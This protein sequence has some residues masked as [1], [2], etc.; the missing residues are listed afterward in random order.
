[1]GFKGGKANDFLSFFGANFRG[2]VTIFIIIAVLII[3]NTIRINIY[4]HREEIGIMKL[5]GATDDYVKGP[6]LFQGLFFGLVSAVIASV[7]LLLLFTSV[8]FLGLFGATSTVFILP[9]VRV[10]NWIFLIILVFLLLIFGGL[11]GYLGS[12]TA[13]KKYLKY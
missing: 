12:Q 13:I 8:K 7:V 5:V 3:F 2:Q 9:G 4:T 6:L 11:L 1:M 10:L